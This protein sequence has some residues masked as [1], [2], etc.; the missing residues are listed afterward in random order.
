[1]ESIK[2]N[3]QVRE[4]NYSI[5]QKAIY[6]LRRI[7]WGGEKKS[8]PKN[9]IICDHLDDSNQSKHWAIFNENKIIASCRL[10]F[11]NNFNEL[12]YPEIFANLNLPF[13]SCF[14]F[15]SRLVIHPN[16]RGFGYSQ[17]LDDIRIREISKR[18]IKL[19]LATARDWRLDYL[20]NKG[21]KKLK[22]VDEKLVQK[23]RI[24]NTSIISLEL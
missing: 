10:S 13:K 20:Q 12:P 9:Q 4:I 22:P 15:Y 19:V 18:E 2:K 3:I 24:G 16:F 21:W 1:M 11:L 5:H 23:Y 6:S 7:A 14:A 8:Y 17:L